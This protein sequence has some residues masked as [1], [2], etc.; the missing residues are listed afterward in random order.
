MTANSGGFLRRIGTWMG[1]ASVMLVV[2]GVAMAQ[3]SEYPT[4]ISRRMGFS[5]G[6]GYVPPGKFDTAPGKKQGFADVDKPKDYRVCIVGAHGRLVV[7]GKSFPMDHGD[8]HDVSGKSLS[9]EN[10]SKDVETHG[11]YVRIESTGQ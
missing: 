11:S 6:Y 10:D 9:F 1:C 2:S 8:C 5:H 3:M 7:D 4:G